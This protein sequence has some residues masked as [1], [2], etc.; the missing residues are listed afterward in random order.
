MSSTNNTTDNRF[1]KT[2]QTVGANGNDVSAADG[3]LNESVMKGRAE[4]GNEVRGVEASEETDRCVDIDTTSFPSRALLQ[5][6]TEAPH[7]A[8]SKIERD[9]ETKGYSTR[10]TDEELD[11]A[12]DLKAKLDKRG[13]PAQ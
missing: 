11:E 8:N 7:S 2:T 9:L 6:I 4:G 1:K 13:N 10:T 3:G 5:N 12:A